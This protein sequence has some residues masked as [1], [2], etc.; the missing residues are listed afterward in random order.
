MRLKNQT[1]PEF[2]EHMVTQHVLPLMAPLLFSKRAGEDK[3][4]RYRRS[5]F[6]HILPS[7]PLPL[8]TLY[9]L[10]TISLVYNHIFVKGFV[11]FMLQY[12]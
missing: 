8:P 1:K 10:P 11:Q 5:A 9:S 12:K 4:K 3:G 6:S 2:P 7:F